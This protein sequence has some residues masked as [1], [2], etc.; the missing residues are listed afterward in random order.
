MLGGC[1]SLNYMAYVRGHPGDY[2]SWGEGW[3]WSDVLP[4][5][6]KSE[7]LSIPAEPLAKVVEK[8]HG[9]D[10]PLGVS[11]RDPTMPS[12]SLFM[13]A[14]KEKGYANG[15]YNAEREI[16]T[17][18]IAS[19][20]QF[21]I[22]NGQRSSTYT[23][24][25]EPHV[26]SRPNLTVMTGSE[27]RQLVIKDG[28]VVGV[29]YVTEEGADS[30]ATAA[31]EVILSCGAYQSPQLLLRSGIGPRNQLE[32]QG[33]KCLVDSPHVGKNLRDHLLLFLPFPMKDSLS[34]GDIVHNLGMGEAKSAMEK[35]MATGKGLAQTSLYEASLFWN[36]GTNPANKH[37][38]DAQTSFLPT[39]FDPDLFSSNL[40]WKDFTPENFD[41]EQFSMEYGTASLF[42]I[43]IQPES[44]GEVL[45]ESDGSVIVN[46]NHLSDERGLKSLVA[47]CKESV[48]IHKQ[49]G[50]SA[51]VGD[52]MIPKQLAAK[53]GK[54]L[55]NDAL[56]KDWVRHYA[57]TCYHPSSTCSIGKVVDQ[58]CRVFNI[59]GLRVADASIM[60]TVISGNTAAPCV[61][62]GEKVAD[63]IAQDHSL[64]GKPMSRL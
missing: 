15:D 13:K 23:A 32:T 16:S 58:R 44:V 22:K 33:I 63:M 31:K 51:Q 19:P 25:L 6:K 14:V 30:I 45:L 48:E 2:I 49:M 35:Y 21:H 54:D 53:H 57:N 18:G 60:P 12:T 42:S 59:S 17:K 50:K 34:L 29:H 4:Y 9:T 1:T 43:L 55:N 24:F 20:H 41:F 40:G 39:G 36:T 28:R 27:A 52:I 11:F 61:M 64:V 56:W 8:A 3:S 7:G 38:H 37:T 26:G 62:I 47:N 46:H 5:F 10:G